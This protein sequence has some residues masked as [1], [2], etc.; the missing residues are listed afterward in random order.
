[1]AARFKTVLKKSVIATNYILDEV[2]IMSINM[3]YKFS[4]IIAEP[5]CTSGSTCTCLSQYTG[6]E[7]AEGKTCA[8]TCTCTSALVLVHVD[9]WQPIFCRVVL[10]DSTWVCDW[11]VC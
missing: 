11:C 1:M 7:C 3:V 5:Q 8:N 4:D 10:N 2:R 9:K 6:D